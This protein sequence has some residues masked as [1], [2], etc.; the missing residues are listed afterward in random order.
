M[1]QIGKFTEAYQEYGHMAPKGLEYEGT[2]YDYADE[3]K[4]VLEE[5]KYLSDE[6][7]MIHNENQD[8]WKPLHPNLIPLANAA[9]ETLKNRVGLKDTSHTL[10]PKQLD[11][12]QTLFLDTI[13]DWEVQCI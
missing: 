1:P 6:Q 3:D 12:T 4:D 2:D 7:D 11:P 5:I 9:K 13:L 8:T 10:D